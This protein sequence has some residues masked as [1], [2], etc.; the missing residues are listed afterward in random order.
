MASSLKIFSCSSFILAVERVV[1]T[2]GE[3]FFGKVNISTI[4]EA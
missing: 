2:L 3:A 1:Y 4:F